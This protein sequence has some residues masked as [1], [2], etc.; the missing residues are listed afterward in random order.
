M[1]YSKEFQNKTV[2]PLL[3]KE[4][5]FKNDF[6]VPRILKI[7][8]NSGIGKISKESKDSAEN[9]FKDIKNIAGQYPV[10]IKSNK[11][12]SGFKLREGDVVGVKVTLRGQKMY[13]FL[14]KLIKIVFPR[15]RDFRGIKKS[16]IDKNGNINIGVK[17]HTVFPEIKIEIVKNLFGLQICITT[18][19]NTKIQARKLLEA[20]GAVF[21][22]HLKR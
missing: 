3:K 8:I 17:E 18:T 12:I 1:T 9:I 2:N 11:A 21:E 4:F 22:H 10:Y 14:E 7:T 6:E 16:A 19:A 13:D 15:I 20:Y 5:G